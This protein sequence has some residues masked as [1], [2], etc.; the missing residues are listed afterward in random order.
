M[1]SEMAATIE[2]VNKS[3]CILLTKKGFVF[4]HLEVNPEK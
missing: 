3:H 4:L 2:L 1:T